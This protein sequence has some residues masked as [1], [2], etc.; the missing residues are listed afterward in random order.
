MMVLCILLDDLREFFTIVSQSVLVA[1]VIR[2]GD[3]EAVL[4]EHTK[5]GRRV[6]TWR[7][8]VRLKPKR[9]V[10]QPVSLT[11]C[12]IHQISGSSLLTGEIG[13]HER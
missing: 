8:T 4:V 10:Q 12:S 6:N 2:C 7:K 3:W 13:K 5:F 11:F 9:W 1:T